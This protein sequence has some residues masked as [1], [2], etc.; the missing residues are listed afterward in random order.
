MPKPSL[1]SVKFAL[2][3]SRTKPLKEVRSERYV[4]ACPREFEEKEEI[5][6][7]EYFKDWT[8]KS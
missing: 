5:W 8:T 2:S 6:L 1:T 3:R 4:T 7:E